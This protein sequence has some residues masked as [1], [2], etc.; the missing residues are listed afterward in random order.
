MHSVHICHSKADIN[1]PIKQLPTSRIIIKNTINLANPINYKKEILR[2]II[3]SALNLL[4]ISSFIY[5]PLF[6]I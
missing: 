6:L 2:V 1:K 3:F 4:S 5:A